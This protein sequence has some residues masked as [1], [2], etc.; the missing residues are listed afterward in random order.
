MQCHACSLSVSFVPLSFVVAAACRKKRSISL[1]NYAKS[2]NQVFHLKDFLSDAQKGNEHKQINEN[3]AKMLFGNKR[4]RY[5]KKC[6]IVYKRIKTIQ[7]CMMRC[8]AV[9]ILLVINVVPNFTI[10]HFTFYLIL[11]Y[12]VPSSVFSRA[13]QQ[14]RRRFHPQIVIETH[15]GG[16]LFSNM[17]FVATLQLTNFPMNHFEVGYI[18]SISQKGLRPP[19]LIFMLPSVLLIFDILSR[20]II[21][22]D[23]FLTF[24]HFVLF[25][26]FSLSKIR[27]V[28]FLCI[29]SHI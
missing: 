3:K 7:E 27:S 18:N 21:R 25:F 13:L 23:H 11:F 4:R 2:E 8:V 6:F 29:W 5:I 12:F 9:L 22:M 15:F 14:A 1:K 17:D 19:S 20:Q 16:T 28:F 10:F 26:F 24:F